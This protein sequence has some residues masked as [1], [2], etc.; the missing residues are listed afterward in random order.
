MSA[1]EFKVGDRVRVVDAEVGEWFKN[2]EYDTVC[3]SLAD[4]GHVSTIESIDEDGMIDLADSCGC[5]LGF[6]PHWLERVEALSEAVKRE[7]R[8]ISGAV[9]RDAPEPSKGKPACDCDEH[10]ASPLCPHH[11]LKEKRAAAEEHLAKARKGKPGRK[12]GP[13]PINDETM[14]HRVNAVMPDPMFWALSRYAEA[15]KITRP[16]AIRRAVHHFLEWCH[17]TLEIQGYGAFHGGDPRLFTPDDECSNPEEREAWEEACRV[18]R[19]TPEPHPPS[20][21]VS[22]PGFRATLKRFGLGVYLVPCFECCD[23]MTEAERAAWT[24]ERVSEAQS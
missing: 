17:G 13:K 19:E 21:H 10:Y 12:R 7:A 23:E 3:K 16:E 2:C 20:A 5:D 6:A 14:T 11:K 4:A 15:N 8:E 1:S 22:G 24:A 18:A 9:H